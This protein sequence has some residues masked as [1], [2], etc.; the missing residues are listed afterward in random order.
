MATTT[1]HAPGAA[2]AT[3]PDDPPAAPTGLRADAAVVAPALV[4]AR[5]LRRAPVDPATGR[6]LAQVVLGWVWLLTGGL[7]AL[8]WTVTAAG[9]VLVGVG[10]PML[11]VGLVVGGWCASAER[12]R[13][14]AQTGVVVDAPAYRRAPRT[15][16]WRW[17]TW[18]SV[19]AD[20]RRWA[21]Q[22][23]ALLAMVVSTVGF[24]V[25]V[26]VGGAGLAAVAFPVYG[27]RSS[28]AG[29]GG[30]SAPVLAGAAVVAGVLL[31][32]CAA[33]AAQGTSL[34]LVG[35]ARALL[36][37]GTRDELRR[38]RA[39]THAAQDDAVHARARADEL[40]AT[41]SAAVAAADAERRRI[42]RD[43]HDGAQ[44]RLV[45][46]GRRARAGPPP[47]GP[48]PR[49]RGRLRSSDAHA[50]VKAD[51]RR[52]ARPRPRHPPRR[53]HRPRARRGAVARWRRAHRCRSRSSCRPGRAGAADA[54]RE[55]AAYFVVAEALTNVAKHAAAA[56]SSSMRWPSS[57][58]AAGCG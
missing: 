44:Q 42:E 23:Y 24:A 3:G 58:T 32:W 5:H 55:A 30:L 25:V 41:R 27:D 13:L 37:P 50:E 26:A 34:V 57:T 36:G 9:L 43:L 12:A 52:A 35:L 7:V 1:T 28:L 45:A 49:R 15:G 11:V 8:C 29:L 10:I 18:W 2:P 53:A 48:R 47:R 14:A 31:V 19:V 51:P 46:P 17:S 33:L 54:R 22:A 20:G 6:A 21:H 40:Q 16:W 4:S 38:A 56:T 39:A